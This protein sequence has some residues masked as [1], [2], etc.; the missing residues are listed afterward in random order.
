MCS[1]AF[2][3]Q[4]VKSSGL[5]KYEVVSAIV[6]TGIVFVTSWTFLFDGNDYISKDE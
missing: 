3:L 1:L 2:G 5:R 6:G 4:T